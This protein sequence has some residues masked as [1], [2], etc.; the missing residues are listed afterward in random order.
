MLNHFF[1]KLI[2]SINK[3]YSFFLVWYKLYSQIYPF[4][5]NSTNLQTNTLHTTHHPEN[6]LKNKR[7]DT[8]DFHFFFPQHK[9]GSNSFRP[10]CQG[11]SHSQPQVET[12]LPRFQPILLDQKKETHPSKPL[13]GVIPFSKGVF[14]SFRGRVCI[15]IWSIWVSKKYIKTL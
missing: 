5:N 14:G 4:K 1:S 2:L 13:C 10:I 15:N 8:C 9:T 12:N 3:L 11:G 6:M 7:P